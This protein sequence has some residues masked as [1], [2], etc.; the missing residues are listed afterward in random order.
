M[1]GANA[2]GARPSAGARLRSL[3]IGG[4]RPG[5]A[6]LVGLLGVIAAVGWSNTLNSQRLLGWHSEIV[7]GT[8]PAPDQYRVLT[9]MLAHAL[10]CLIGPTSVPELI[11][12]TRVVYLFVHFAAFTVAGFFFVAFCR[13]YLSLSGSLLSCALLLGLC[14]V[15]NL[16]GQIQVT[17]PMNLMFLTMG[18]WAIDRRSLVALPAAMALG[19]INRESILVL[20]G[21]YVLMEW[22]RPKRAVLLTALLVTVAWAAAYGAVRAAY[23]MRAYSVDLVMLHYN[24]AG[25]WQWALPLLLMAPL[26]VAAL[27]RPVSA[28]PG[29]LRRATLVIPPWMLLHLVVAR[30][31]EV[32]LIIPLLPILIPLAVLGVSRAGTQEAS[33]VAGGEL[34]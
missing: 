34:P 18:L 24:L 21:Y 17:D 8:A 4:L 10:V 25:F 5:A 16:R 22:P 23:G 11:M 32:R 15:A 7:A 19:A 28:W 1:A 9:P 13:R 2:D 3:R 33:E 29:P 31:E 20:M 12:S 27:Q 26:A 6:A 14:A 30:L